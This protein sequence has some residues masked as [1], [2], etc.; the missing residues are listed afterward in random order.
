MHH[1]AALDDG[2][3]VA[4]GDD[5]LDLERGEVAERVVEAGLVTL[6]RL[7]RLVGAVEQPPDLLQL[8]LGAA[9]VDVDHAHLL[10]RRD[11]GHVERAG[12]TLG[13]AVARAGL[14]G[15]N[16]RVGHEVD[17]GAGDAAAVGRDDDRA[18]HLRQFGETL[19]A[20]R[21]VDEEAAGADREHVG[22]VVQ[23]EQCAG[24]GAHDAIDA[25]TQRSTR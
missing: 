21:G 17:V 8:A 7:Q 19:G 11:H 22:L 6:E 13:R 15:G 20:E 16:R 12:D 3:H 14:A 25:V 18:V 1:L 24:L 5:V 23:D 2:D 4:D 10:G 9:G